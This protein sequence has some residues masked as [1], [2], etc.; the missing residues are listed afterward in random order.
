MRRVSN[1][2]KILGI[3]GAAAFV[4]CACTQPVPDYFNSSSRQGQISIDDVVPADP[5]GDPVEPPDP[6]PSPSA[7]PSVTPSPDPSGSPQPSPSPSESVSP[8]PSPSAPVTPL[9]SPTPLVCGG[10]D[11]KLQAEYKCHTIGNST[12]GERNEHDNYHSEE[13]LASGRADP[14]DRTDNDEVF[15]Q[16]LPDGSRRLHCDLKM[17]LDRQFRGRRAVP[18][19][20]EPEAQFKHQDRRVCDKV[21][22][23]SV[24]AKVNNIPPVNGSV[25]FSGGIEVCIPKIY[26]KA[27]GKKEG[28]VLKG[29]RDYVAKIL[30]D[31]FTEAGSPRVTIGRARKGNTTIPLATLPGTTSGPNYC[32]RGS[33]Q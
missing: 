4:A 21:Y 2:F 19:K 13:G 6:T 8:T 25:H 16:D 10:T 33:G 14:S 30:L 26:V 23:K 31:R 18:V 28:G 32:V 1:S 11:L 22:A 15:A 29:V 9:P 12:S 17:S 3:Y 20:L 24:V 27:C 5:G 7:S